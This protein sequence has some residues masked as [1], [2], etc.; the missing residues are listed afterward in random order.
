MLQQ[1][2]IVAELL[3]F[4]RKRIKDTV[5]LDIRLICD[6]LFSCW[7]F[8]LSTKDIHLASSAT[9]N[10]SS[11]ADAAAFLMGDCGQK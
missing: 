10:P 5:L 6:I 4:V 3:D 2:L 9:W 8:A 1:R 7:G 11:S